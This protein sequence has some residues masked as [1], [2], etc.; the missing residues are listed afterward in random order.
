[1][2][3]APTMTHTKRPS[4]QRMGRPINLPVND[5]T[6]YDK[7]GL[8][9]DVRKDDLFRKNMDEV[10]SHVAI[11]RSDQDRQL[12]IVGAT[13]TPVQN[14][15]LFK[16]LAGLSDFAPLTLDSAGVLDGGETVWIRAKC[17]ALSF[18][19]GGGDITEAFVSL[20]NG[21]I[22]N[23]RLGIQAQAERLICTNGMRMVMP[24]KI[25]YKG[26]LTTGFN[27][28]HTRGITETLLSVQDAYVRATS[29]F[30]S[31]EEAMRLLVSKPITPEAQARLFSEPWAKPENVDQKGETAD[32]EALG[33]DES[34]RAI[35]IREAREE[36][37]KALLEAPTNQMPATRNTLYS[38]YQTVNE[39]LDHEAPVRTAT[40]TIEAKEAARFASAHFDGTADRTKAKAFE[41]AMELA[42]A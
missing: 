33:D 5:P 30:K 6:A 32:L 21:H 4:W 7:S 18:D 13:F 24:A 19:L 11:V 35:A 15:D 9:W 12:G 40:G 10:R 1:M 26:K 31:T 8:N 17:D 22:G 41:I 3:T 27:L 34:A 42:G 2:T 14:A 28:R 39:Y 20:V 29:A 23:R 25:Q 36:R 38:L 37:L 16:F